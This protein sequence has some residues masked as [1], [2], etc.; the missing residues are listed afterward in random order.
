MSNTKNKAEVEFEILEKT[1][2]NAIIV[3]FKK[4]ILALI[5]KFADSGQSGSAAPYTA[6]AIS[7]A[8]EHLCL[9]EPICPITGR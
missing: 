7:Q 9:Q 5:D 2:K 8:V 6:K 3:P 4:E 1:G